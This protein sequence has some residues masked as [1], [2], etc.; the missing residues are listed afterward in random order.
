MI[1]NSINTESIVP[2][3]YTHMHD[4]S[5]VFRKYKENFDFGLT[6]DQYYFNKDARDRKTNY[7][8]QYVLSDLQSLS[9][10]LELKI[11]HTAD[12][13]RAFTTTVKFGEKYLKTNFQ[14]ASAYTTGLST[15]SST[16]VDSSEFTNLSSHFFFTFTLTSVSLS[17]TIQPSLPFEERVIVTQEFNSA[18]YYLTANESVNAQAWFTPYSAVSADIPTFRYNLE[19]NK[20]ILTNSTP[21]LSTIDGRFCNLSGVLTLSPIDTF[22]GEASALSACIFDV[23]RHELTKDYKTLPSSYVK[24]TSSYNT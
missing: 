24:Y 13:T 16:F 20:I 10:V 9:T 14:F 18:T 2:I 7:N 23:N 3:E 22:F 6:V 5:L 15:L 4:E 19:N 1:I 17:S 11:P 8:T 12:A 21:T